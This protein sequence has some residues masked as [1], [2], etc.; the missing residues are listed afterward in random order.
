MV[1]MVALFSTLLFVIGFCWVYGTERLMI[2][3]IFWY[4]PTHPGITKFVVIGLTSIVVPIT[5]LVNY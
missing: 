1:T 4:D 5:L 2:D 3:F